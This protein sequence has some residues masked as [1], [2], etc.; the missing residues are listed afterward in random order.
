MNKRL[1]SALDASG[2]THFANAFETQGVDD[3]LID[4]LNDADLQAIGVAKLGD[5]KKLLKAFASCSSISSPTPD[6]QIGTTS[7]S[8]QDFAHVQELE[9]FIRAA[10]PAFTRYLR[11]Q[12]RLAGNSD[13]RPQYPSAEIARIGNHVIGLMNKYG[14]SYDSPKV[15]GE[16]I[17][18]SSWSEED[19]GAGTVLCDL[20]N[21]LL[22]NETIPAAPRMAYLLA[23]VSAKVAPFMWQSA[24][25][26]RLGFLEHC[27][28]GCS[29]N[30]N[31]ALARFEKVASYYDKFTYSLAQYYCAGK[32]SDPCGVC[33][34]TPALENVVSNTP[35]PRDLSKAGEWAEKY[36]KLVQGAD[37]EAIEKALAD[38]KKQILDQL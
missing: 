9:E 8:G 24:I 28:I 19:F 22:F 1:L 4:D 5:R 11:E 34:D 23:S 38:L 31:S 13:E 18:P 21:R 2:L 14:L 7:D 36:E 26:W 30:T 20:E 37:N 3:S 32:L 35:F 25:E 27:G 12:D 16:S 29:Q 33:H 15:F 6:R 17:E 10:E